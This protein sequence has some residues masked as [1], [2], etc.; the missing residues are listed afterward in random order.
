MTP[1]PSAARANSL[2]ARDIANALHSYTD[3]RAH[4]ENGLET[5]D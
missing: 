3:L 4:Q 2:A 1:P 5:R